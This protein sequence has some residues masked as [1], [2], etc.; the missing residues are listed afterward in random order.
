[1]PFIS[2]EKFEELERSVHKQGLIQQEL[3][4]E[5]M[6][7]LNKQNAIIAQLSNENESLKAENVKLRQQLMNM[8]R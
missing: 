1:M 3:H 7:I 5:T 6:M 2:L 4:Q 8:R